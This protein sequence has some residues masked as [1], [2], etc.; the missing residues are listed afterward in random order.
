MYI[1]NA[2]NDYF[3]NL[4]NNIA[5]RLPTSDQ[6]FNTF[7]GDRCPHSLFLAPVT[8]AEISIVISKLPSGKAPGFD[9]LNSFVVKEARNALA[10]LLVKLFNRSFES[11]VFFAD[12]L[13]IGKV[14]YSNLV[15]NMIFVTI[16]PNPLYRSCQK[17]LKN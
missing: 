12:S 14:V 4:G 2:F 13:K 11:G 8:E 1:A 7:L 3:V 17:F 6:S 5:S 15:I 9:G 16:D 10:K